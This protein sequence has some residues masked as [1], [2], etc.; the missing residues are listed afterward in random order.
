MDISEPLV[1]RDVDGVVALIA[2]LTARVAHSSDTPLSGM[3]LSLG[4]SVV[5]EREIRVAPFLGWIRVPI[6]GLMAEATGL[7]VRVANDVRAF[8]YAEAWFGLGR[9]A[10][11]FVTARR[12]CGCK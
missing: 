11:L 5:G 12:Q 8:T 10:N 1:N 3:G 7:P 4:A 2:A 6:A 9:G